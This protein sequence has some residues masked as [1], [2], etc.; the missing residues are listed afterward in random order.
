MASDLPMKSKIL[1]GL[2]LV[3]FMVVLLLIV[4][5]WQ[6]HN[7]VVNLYENKN[8]E[9]LKNTDQGIGVVWFDNYYTVQKLASNVYAIGEPRYW[10][11]NYNYLIVGNNEALLIDAGPGVR[12][13][14]PVVQSITDLPYTLINTH[15]HFDH[16]G[17]GITFSRQAVIDLPHLRNR[18]NGDNLPL[19]L[20]EH[21][22]KP[23]GYNTPVLKVDEWL[24]P[25]STINIGNRKIDIIY[26][27]GHTVESISLFDRKS[28]ILFTGDWFTP[29]LGPMFANSNMGDFLLATKNVLCTVSDD[30]RVFG[31]HKYV[32]EG[33]APEQSIGDIKRVQDGVKLIQSRKLKPEGI[34]PAVYQVTPDIELYADIEFLQDWNATYPALIGS[35]C[36]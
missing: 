20:L 36:K 2:L 35:K 18:A 9:L 32:D 28:N 3:I 4:A 19:T 22:G 26:T 12:D 11:R 34:Y 31:A 10:Q 30:T 27:P 8:P 15:F 29:I 14:R 5:V 13:I 1:H 7:L 33:G 23:E 25:N 17:N 6:R 16:V 21:L 24:K